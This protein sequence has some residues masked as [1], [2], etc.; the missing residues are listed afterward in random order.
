MDEIDQMAQGTVRGGVVSGPASPTREEVIWAYRVLLGREPESE[1]VIDACQKLPSFG[2]LRI[3]LIQSD[4]F[5]RTASAEMFSQHSTIV[6][7]YLKSGF[8]MYLDLADKAVSLPC[9]AGNYEP[10]E[11]EFVQRTLK[12]GGG[13]IDMGANLG[14]FTL[15]A[16]KAVGPKGRVLCFEPRSGAFKALEQSIIDNQFTDRVQYFHAGLWDEK[17]QLSLRW[18]KSGTNQGGATLDSTLSPQA[19]E[20]ETVNLMR[21]DDLPVDHTIHLIK[22]DVEGAEFRAIKG[23]EELIE[24]DHPVILSE[25][26]QTRLQNVSGVD[27]EQYL[28]LLWDWDYACYELADSGLGAQLGRVNLR[29][30]PEIRNVVFVPNTSKRAAE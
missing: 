6:R 16:A 11:T 13:F 12:P 17:A 10:Q 26:L 22:I 23:A 25:I 4:E 1:R 28:E 8:Y 27:V 19:H 15:L 29:D 7:S 20:V 24:R 5:Q 21:L 14:W 30:W 3:N 2:Q 18:A 9:L